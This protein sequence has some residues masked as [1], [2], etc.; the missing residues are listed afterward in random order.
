MTRGGCAELITPS[1]AMRRVSASPY[2]ISPHSIL[3][4]VLAEGRP[5]RAH[6]PGGGGEAADQVLHADRAENG[7]STAVTG[8]LWIYRGS[9]KMSRIGAM[10]APGPR[11]GNHNKSSFIF[12]SA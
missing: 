5:G 1:S 3:G 8:S 7:A 12:I 9:S 11:S 2:P 6:P 4:V 10:A